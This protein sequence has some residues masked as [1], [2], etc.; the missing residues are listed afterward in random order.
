VEFAIIYP[1]KEKGEYRIL[2]GYYDD[3]GVVK[4][5]KQKGSNLTDEEKT[6]VDSS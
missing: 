3:E 6:Q 1:P 2:V 4:L 5:L